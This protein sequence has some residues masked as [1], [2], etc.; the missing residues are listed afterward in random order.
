MLFAVRLAALNFRPITGNGFWIHLRVGQDIRRRGTIPRV[1]DYSAG[2]Y[3]LRF[4]GHEWLGG[5]GPAVVERLFD[6]YGATLLREVVSFGVV[7]LL[8]G[9]LAPE[10]RRSHLGS[11]DR[12][13][14]LVRGRQGRGGRGG[15][16]L[17]RDACEPVRGRPARVPGS[18]VAGGGRI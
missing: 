18:N 17:G 4:V 10:S 15:R 14:V 9:A 6:P 1:D 16:L 11:A 8:L 3:G 7:G 13:T 2:G 5:V 12:P